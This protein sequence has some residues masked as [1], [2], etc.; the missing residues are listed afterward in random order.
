MIILPLLKE[1]MNTDV[2]PLSQGLYLQP[3]SLILYICLTLLFG[4]MKSSS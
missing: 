4:N 3:Q 2:V 1:I